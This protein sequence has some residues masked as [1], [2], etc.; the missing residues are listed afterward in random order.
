MTTTEN[1]RFNR[2]ELLFYH[3][4]VAL[5]LYPTEAT[6]ANFHLEVNGGHLDWQVSSVAQIMNALSPLFSTVVDLTLD[7][8]AHSTSSV[9]QHNQAERTEWHKLLGSFRNVESLRVHKSLAGELARSLQ[10]DG[11][12]PLEA[13]PELRELV[14]HSSHA[15]D[16]T[17]APFIHEREAAG[18]PVNLIG[19]AFPVGRSHYRVFSLTGNYYIDPV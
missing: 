3:E 15:D 12:P 7:Y 6:L 18:R 9:E 5:F 11:E 19:E 4:A 10:S 13:L 14:C 16:K 17:F 1:L 8:R 2:A